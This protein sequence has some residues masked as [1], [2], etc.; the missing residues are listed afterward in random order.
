MPVNADPILPTWRRSRPPR[1]SLDDPLDELYEQCTSFDQSQVPAAQGG[2]TR[3]GGRWRQAPPSSSPWCVGSTAERTQTNQKL[4]A[5]R[6]RRKY[7]SAFIQLFTQ[8]RLA[9]SLVTLATVA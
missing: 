6:G 2:A 1:L 9:A 5:N 3:T 8:A 7:I 4:R